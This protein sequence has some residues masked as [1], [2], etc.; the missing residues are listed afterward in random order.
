MHRPPSGHPHQG[1][2][3]SHNGHGPYG[4]VSN[5]TGGHPLPPHCPPGNSGHPLPPHRPDQPWPAPGDMHGGGANFPQESYPQPEWCQGTRLFPFNRP[6]KDTL[7][8]LLN[9]ENQT[10]FTPN[11]LDFG[12]PAAIG[13]TLTAITA[14]PT[15]ET[16]WT[17][18]VILTYNRRYLETYLGATHLHLY[19]DAVISKESII[20]SMKD[21]YRV[22]LDPEDF[23]LD[24]IGNQP[25]W[26]QMGQRLMRIRFTGDSLIWIGAIEVIVIPDNRLCAVLT[27][28]N[29]S[30][31]NYP[32]MDGGNKQ[33][34]DSFYTGL[35]GT[36]MFRELMQYRAGE[37]IERR[38]CD[39]RGGYWMP[40]VRITGSPWRFDSR[41]V[42]FNIQGARV[43]YNGPAEGVWTT[44]DCRMNSVLVIELGRM[45]KNL[46][47]NL[48]IPY[49][50][51]REI[52]CQ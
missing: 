34:A 36:F 8:D 19:T 32:N 47:G 26:L 50:I 41:E 24:V 7:I 5:Q 28:T 18:E 17:Q 14:Y 42:E 21:R 10:D 4:N 43:K 48:I 49:E 3:H 52:P 39:D 35:D 29:L 9:R 44:G 13:N 45:C 20:Q 1:G 12:Q 46:R 33:L 25:T 31:F 11:Q 27:V 23:H 37:F 40:G 16:G 2:P 38:H 30:G 51:R 15:P 22:W 6:P